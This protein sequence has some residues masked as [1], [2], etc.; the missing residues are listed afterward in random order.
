MRGIKRCEGKG[1]QEEEG[2]RE[3]NEENGMKTKVEGNE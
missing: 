2:I 3:R 1:R